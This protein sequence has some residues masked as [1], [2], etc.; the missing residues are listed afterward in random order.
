MTSMSCGTLNAALKTRVFREEHVV[1]KRTERT[2]EWPQRLQA[3]VMM[4]YARVASVVC[5]GV[6]ELDE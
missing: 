5:L 6:G 3:M 2:G 1:W 4:V